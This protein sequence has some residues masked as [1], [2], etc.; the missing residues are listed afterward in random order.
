MRFIVGLG[1]LVIANIACGGGSG[2]VTVQ[3]YKNTD[4]TQCVCFASPDGPGNSIPT[5]IPT[6]SCESP[7][8]NVPCCSDTSWPGPAPDDQASQ[9]Q[10][11]L[12]PVMCVVDSF[13]DCD[14]YPGAQPT[15]FGDTAVTSCPTMDSQS[16]QARCAIRSEGDCFCQYDGNSPA[17]TPVS[18]C[19]STS[20]FTC[21]GMDSESVAQSTC[22]QSSTGSSGSNSQCWYPNWESDCGTDADCDPGLM[23]TNIGGNQRCHGIPCSTDQDCENTYG[24]LEKMGRTYCAS[25][26]GTDG[27]CHF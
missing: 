23:C 14:C 9:C 15:G 13:G 16:H 17:G 12:R 21:A 8:S 24:S 7:A 2:S 26:C 19:S 18:T 3:C 4:G 27:L 22:G 6:P 25:T 5:L 11:D 10:C 1:L 20:T